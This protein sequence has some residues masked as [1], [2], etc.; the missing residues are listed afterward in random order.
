VDQELMQLGGPTTAVDKALQL[1]LAFPGGGS[2]VGV[3][4]LARQFGWTKSTT[5]RLV[6]ILHRNGYIERSGNRYRL[7]RRLHDLGALVYESHPGLLLDVVSP[8]MVQLLERTGQKVNL[9]VLTGSEVALIGRLHG[10]RSAANKLGLGTRYP[11]H[12]SAMGKALLAHSPEQI[13]HLMGTDL[14]AVTTATIRD[15]QQLSV[16]LAEVRRRGLAWSRQELLK[17][18]NC[19]AVALLGDTGRPLAAL[20]L[21]GPAATF[22]PR[23]D[24]EIL[25]SVAAEAERSLRAALRGSNGNPTISAVGDARGCGV[26]ASDRRS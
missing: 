23:T 22:E 9:G 6:S 4:E 8:F 12:A 7:G 21:S 18:V 2:T 16:E 26:A 11:A 15:P 13:Q 19:A 10:P 24:G 17:N 3:S 5:F 1:L 20:G 14:T 25:R